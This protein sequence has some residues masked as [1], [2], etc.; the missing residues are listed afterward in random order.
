MATDER[1]SGRV[2]F[3]RIAERYDRS[4]PG[5]PDELFDVLPLTGSRVLEIGCG[6]GQASVS[7]A[8]RG[9]ELTAVELGEHLA[10][11][12]ARKLAAY[13]TARVELADFDR[14]TPPAAEFDVVF[15]ATSFHWLNPATRVDRS[16][17]VLRTGGMLATVATH[18]V[19]GG[20]QRFFEDVQACY[21]RFDAR[22]RPG[23]PRPATSIPFDGQLGP[24]F[25]APEYHRYEWSASYTAESYLDLLGTY[26]TTLTLPEVAA[27]GLLRSIG[28]L[29]NGR[30]KGH[31][32]KQY[33]TEL[34]TTTRR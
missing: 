4:R 7:L 10:E 19:A 3:D 31:I 33:L 15:A 2:A 23:A 30:Y 18:H 1:L 29:I 20:T 32:T 12:A 24:R 14:W 16:A 34:R 17:D 6:T 25:R 28:D 27:R 5:Y 8:S 22:T 21:R 9:A 11:L 13:P 26:S